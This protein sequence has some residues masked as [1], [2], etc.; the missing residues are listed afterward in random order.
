[1]K[2]LMLM[3][4]TLTILCGAGLEAVAQVLEIQYLTVPREHMEE[5]MELHKEVI[6]LT[7]SESTVT[8]H[9]VY[10]HAFAG[11]YTMTFVNRYETAVSMEQDTSFSAIG[12]YSDSIADS[13]ERAAF[14]ERMD[15]YFDWYLTGH[16]DEVRG[17]AEGGFFKEDV[18]P[19][20]RH[21][22][23]VGHYNPKFSDLSEFTELYTELLVEPGR[24]AGFANGVV[25]GTHYRGSGDTF[26]AVTYYPS[27]DAFAKAQAAAA[28]GPSTADVER[29]DRFWNIA[30][31]HSDD[32]MVS[33]G[34]LVDG[35]F[36]TTEW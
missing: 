23:T 13:T 28:G 18:D 32:I 34:S 9:W 3:G 24:E 16:W 6:E 25:F 29:M 17:V 21:V 19:A 5:F 11:R 33:L 15:N 36:V 12:R 7:A 26:D 10:A 8:G 1:M 35:S 22:V 27:W 31:R 30:G 2:K 4:L 20:Q 14:D